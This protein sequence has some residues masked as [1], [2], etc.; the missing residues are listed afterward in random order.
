MTQTTQNTM[1]AAAIDRF[2]GIETIRMQTLPVP[3]VGPDEVLIRVESAGVAVWDVFERE[4]GFAKMFGVEPKFPYVL[5][6]DGAGTVAAVGEKISRVKKGDRVYAV[7]L[8]NP[9]GGFYAEYAAVKAD[10]VSLI[11]GKLTIEQASV[12]PSDA[13]TAL[14]GLDEIL[15]LKKAETLMIFGASGGV[16]HLA[17]QLAK[18]MGARVF[19]VASGD[20]GVALAKRLGADA[21][22]NGR[23][24]DVAAAA[25]K[26][27]PDGLD[28]AL[29]TAG[30]EAAD[31]ALAAVRDGGRAAH[32][33]GIMPEPKARSGVRMS[34][35]DVEPNRE[36][37][38][39]LNRLIEL[40]EAGP[41]EVHVARTFALDQAADAQRALGQHFL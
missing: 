33:N 21:V 15:G 39:K 30:G 5:G 27:A 14:R 28:A 31:R 8:V 3:E 37:I 9:K 7:A 41:F 2:G 40:P 13:M 20:D 12:M 36:A 10:N 35:Y 16:G 1:R 11:P 17:V 24:D 4:G 25:R 19:A 29:M 22:V 6:T 34:T 26:F 18:R 32:P 23:K 38:E